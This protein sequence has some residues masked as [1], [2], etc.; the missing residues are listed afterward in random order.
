MSVLVM[1]MVLA[2]PSTLDPRPVVR[3]QVRVVAVFLRRVEM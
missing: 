2:R 1:M 3:M